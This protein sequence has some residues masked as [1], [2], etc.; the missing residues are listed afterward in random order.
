MDETVKLAWSQVEN[1]YQRRADLVPQL[2]AVVGQYASHEKETLE[3]VINARSAAL[4]VT[5]DINNA[6]ELKAFY[7]KQSGLTQA[8]SKL[9]LLQEQY[10][11][12]K[13]APLFS[14]LNVQLE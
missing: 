12:L 3:S 8:L 7:E 13:A 2:V 4:S 5:V 11:N 10:P 6:D 14:D 9:M 1:Q